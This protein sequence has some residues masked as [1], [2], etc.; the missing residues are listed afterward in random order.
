MVV[1]HRLLLGVLAVVLL[2]LP[3]ASFTLSSCGP[4]IPLALRSA[5]PF[6]TFSMQMQDSS[7]SFAPVRV[8]AEVIM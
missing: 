6:P 3:A 7:R 4:A 1:A 2:P 5:R 8:D